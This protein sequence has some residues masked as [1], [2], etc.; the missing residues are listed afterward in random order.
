VATAL[1]FCPAA[2]CAWARE[3]C[4]SGSCGLGFLGNDF[5]RG[6]SGSL[7]GWLFNR[8]FA[9]HLR[10]NNDWIVGSQARHQFDS[11]GQSD[12]GNVN[13]MSQGEIGQIN[14]DV[15]GQIVRQTLDIN[16][17]HDVAHHAA[18]FHPRA[19]ICMY[20][21]KRYLHVDLAVGGN[22]L[23]IDMQHFFFPWVHLHVAQ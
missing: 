15:L 4:S 5:G 23:E 20:K 16:V 12:L 17:V 6:R 21:V 3:I 9:R 10:G 7:R 22:A 13:R 18:F 1:S 8:N 14:L 2:S 19:Y 11:F